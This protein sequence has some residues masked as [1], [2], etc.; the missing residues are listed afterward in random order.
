MVLFFVFW[1]SKAG[2]MPPSRKSASEANG[3][4]DVVWSDFRALF[5]QLEPNLSVWELSM[6][7]AGG[8]FGGQNARPKAPKP[9]QD[10]YHETTLTFG[11]Q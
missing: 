6:R 10:L 4:P 9:L 2:L 7:A 3:H 8:G 1:L 5:A 11:S